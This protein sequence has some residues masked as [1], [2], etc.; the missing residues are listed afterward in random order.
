[1]SSFSKQAEVLKERRQVYC[2]WIRASDRSN[3]PLV[4]I[5]IDPAMTS[6]ESSHR[7]GVKAHEAECTNDEAVEDW[8]SWGLAPVTVL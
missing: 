8:P 4:S 1:M 2:V 7:D 3:S 5:W 6:F